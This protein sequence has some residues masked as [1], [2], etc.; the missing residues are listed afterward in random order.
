MYAI[1]YAS[2]FYFQWTEWYLQKFL[3]RLPWRDYQNPLLKS[4]HYSK[5]YSDS[6]KL[7]IGLFTGLSA[8]EIRSISTEGYSAKEKELLLEINGLFKNYLNPNI[9]E[10]PSEQV[11]LDDVLYTLTILNEYFDLDEENHNLLELIQS[12]NIPLSRRLSVYFSTKTIF[13]DNFEPIKLLLNSKVF[14]YS[15][16]EQPIGKLKWMADVL[17]VFIK[18]SNTEIELDQVRSIQKT[19]MSLIESVSNDM[20]SVLWKLDL[21]NPL[22]S[23]YQWHKW[24][25]VLRASP[26]QFKNTWTKVQGYEFFLKLINKNKTSPLHGNLF[27]PHES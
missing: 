25:N 4:T 11:L 26:D 12:K 6:T 20:Q 22:K 1:M 24:A 27:P 8:L 19:I 3:K 21:E 14:L 17:Q 15:L 7:L 2:N 9:W 5:W 23:N 13:L 10:L 16:G 18:S